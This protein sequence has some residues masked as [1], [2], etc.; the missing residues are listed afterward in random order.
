REPREQLEVLARTEL[1]V[2]RQAL[3]DDAD[4]LQGGPLDAP[5]RR[6]GR[7]REQR[8]QRRLARPVRPEQ[9]EAV[10]GLQGEV[11]RA[12]HLTA[13]EALGEPRAGDQRGARAHA[14]AG[15][16]GSTRTGTAMSSPPPANPP[17]GQGSS[18]MRRWKK[19]A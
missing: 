14:P 16:S 17:R 2:Q 12:E 8:E 1:P 18:W 13:S 3:R 11:D 15:G 7:P 19:I 9:R 5:R 10:A 4:L 6:L